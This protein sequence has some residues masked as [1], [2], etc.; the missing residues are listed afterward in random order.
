MKSENKYTNHL[1]SEKSPYLLQHAHNPV[2]WFAWGDAAFE[3]AKKENKLVLI[4][5]GYSACHWCH[6]MEH[7][8]FEDEQVAALM[9]K[10]FVNI[11]VDREERPDVDHVYMTAVQLMTQHGGWPLNCFVLP[12]GRPIYGG[13]YF[14]KE[15]WM[16]LL[17]N[18]ANL[19]Q[20]DKQKV[21]DYANQLTDGIKRSD[22]LFSAS[23][24]ELS[25]ISKDVIEK[26]ALA[27]QKRFDTKNGGSIG[28]PKFMMPN[29]YLFL[30]RYAHLTNNEAILNHV[31]FTL[32]KMAHGG[33]Y[34]QLGGGFARYSTDEQWKIPHFEKMLYDNAQ[35]ISLYSEAYRQNKNPLYK[36]VVYQTIAFVERELTSPEFGFYSALDADSE[37][38]EGLFYIWTK[39]DLQNIV[40]KDFDV[41]ADYYSVN[42]I[43]Y[44]EHDNYIL[45]RNLPDT[46][47]ALKHQISVDELNKIITACNQ[48]L[49]AERDK[50]VRPGLDD[51]I[52]ASW[53]GLM[54][55][56]LCD[57]YSAFTDDKFLQ[58]AVKNANFIR[59]KL[60]D[61]TGSLTRC[62]KDKAYIDAFL[63]DYAFVIDAY[64]KLF[65]TTGNEAWLGIAELMM[66]Q[67]LIN[68]FDEKKNI[69]YFSDKNTNALISK[70]I[71]MHDNVIPASNSQMAKNLFALSKISGNLEYEEVS[72]SMLNHVAEEI[73]NY[74]SGHSNWAILATQQ[75][76]PFYEVCIVG[77]AVDEFMQQAQEHYN[78]NAIFVYSKTASTIALLKERYKNDETVVYVCQNH[79]C[80]A[81]VKTINEAL[82][83]LK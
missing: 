7:Q 61:D 66:R 12:D 32:Q 74:P 67:T 53:N 64:I 36:Q 3:K 75:A 82:N 13:T 5:V 47:I 25:T 40:K 23:A 6:V 76:L 62:Y 65:S 15:Q 10:Y 49:M 11:K 27:F 70:K 79:T 78:P 2:N 44:W 71:E 19:H 42:E 69:F 58:L 46:E 56:A 45:L 20:T 41:F 8:C 31:H 55:A 17:Q 72:K 50:R 57:A 33:L 43:G 16:Q 29:N 22:E 73:A 52:I 18:L 9:N 51:K 37:G 39:E 21:E 38:V 28:A 60:I 34:D 83:Q 4:S 1:I 81:P 48:K 35:L 54:C 26:A 63:E 80:S 24:N 77:K 14:P 30:L 68:F 59:K